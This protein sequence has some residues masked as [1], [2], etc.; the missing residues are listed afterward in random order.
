MRTH[1]EGFT[2]LELVVVMLC[3]TLV[4]GAAMTIL[5]TGLRVEKKTQEGLSSQQT[6][7][8]ILTLVE[9]LTSDGKIR[10]VETV[11]EEDW[12]LRGQDNGALLTYN[13][14]AQ[15]LSA[16][17][18][19][20]ME[21]VSSSS[22]E[23]TDEKL[24]T[25]SLETEGETYEVSHFCRTGIQSTV[26][27]DRA[28]VIEKAEDLT[29]GEEPGR[30]ALLIALAAQYGSDG[31]ILNGAGYPTGQYF[32]QW[33][34]PSWELDT[35]WC[36]C[37]LSWALA[38]IQASDAGPYLEGSV[39]KFANVDSWMADFQ[40]QEGRWKGKTED[41]IP[42]P[43]DLVFFDWT[44]GNNP[45]HV[46]AVFYVDEAGGVF[47]TIEGNSGGRV[48]LHVYP[49]DSKL[50]VGYGVLNWKQPTEP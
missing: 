34:E 4:I 24:L 21:D 1:Q 16:G 39:P 18:E 49:L 23:L 40:S 11:G 22:A 10:E 47:Y 36:A 38:Q 25:V 48:R 35:P 8:T 29:T 30:A 27:N 43:G 7:Y 41:Y 26:L 28:D 33:Y 37:F 42:S 19:V 50:I 14:G 9:Q 46:G 20:L 13:S 45:A 5:F 3:S 44:G 32:S 12:I 6:A 17:G 31:Q 15:T 2:L